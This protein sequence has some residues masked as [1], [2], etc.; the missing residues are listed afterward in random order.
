MKIEEDESND[1]LLHMPII[2]GLILLVVMLLVI[3]MIILRRMNK[4]IDYD[5]NQRGK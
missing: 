2:L 5:V 4:P 3:A 1:L